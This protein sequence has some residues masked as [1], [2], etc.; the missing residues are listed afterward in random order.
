MAG[1]KNE[2]MNAQNMNFGTVANGAR[3]FV[4]AGQIPIATG[5]VFPAVEIVPATLTPGAGISIVNGA[6]TITISTAGGVAASSFPV[7]ASSPPGTNPVVPTAGG[8]LTINGAASAALG[9][10]VRSQST[11]ANTITIN[12]QRGSAQ[13][14]SN[15][16]NPG[17][18]SMNSADFTVDSNGW[19]SASG[20]GIMK[21]LT[22]DVGAAI[23]PTAG[24][25]NVRGE[26]GTSFPSSGLE[27]H[28]DGLPSTM[29]LENKLYMT[30][31][32]VEPGNTVGARGNYAT[33]QDAINAAAATGGGGRIYVR[34][35]CIENLSFPNVFGNP[36]EIIGVCSDGNVPE[37]IAGPLIKRPQITGNHTITTPNG[38]QTDIIFKNLYFQADTQ[39]MTIAANKASQMKFF[40]CAGTMVLGINGQNGIDLQFYDCNFTY[41]DT[42][43][44]FSLGTG[45]GTVQVTSFKSVFRSGNPNALFLKTNI[46][47]GDGLY[48]INYCTIFGQFEMNNTIGV[49]SLAC[50]SSL[51]TTFGG[52]IIATSAVAGVNICN[53]YHCTIEVPSGDFITGSGTL[54]YADL[55]FTNAGDSIDVA[56]TPAPQIW[57]PW[58][59]DAAAAV[60][61]VRGTASFDSASFTVTDG[62]VQFTGS[63]GISW[64]DFAGG[65][66]A[67]STGYNATAA[68]VYTLPAGTTN[69][70]TIEIIDYIGGG[71]VVTAQGGDL[72]RVGNTDS[73]VNGTATST[74][75]GDALRLIF[76]AVGQTWTSAPSAA[77][78]WILA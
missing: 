4:S 66:L 20:T 55:I 54:N 73:S 59:E 6:G 69:G 13:A 44:D 42:F 39:F 15:V 51:L 31:F 61:S 45:A 34:G 38:N 11:A 10:P 48:Q 1:F 77:G 28:T 30:K 63:T 67:I 25:I 64:V 41:G 37:G 21:T 3:E 58:A 50:N 53:L 72:I 52:P 27:T 8:V 57:K 60:G 74:Q 23:T 68:G 65:P 47:Q 29:Y 32:F 26:I 62:W 49:D 78:V 5:N 14:S 7:Q 76:R 70:E 36:I 46:N 18:V 75:M 43:I 17:L 35:D 9:S 71:V 22:P 40:N 33:L 24:T 16:N 19:V 2:V 12:V 56:I